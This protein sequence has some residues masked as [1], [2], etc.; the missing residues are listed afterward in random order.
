MSCPTGSVCEGGECVVQPR[1][2]PSHA[3]WSSGR[4]AFVDRTEA[5]G[6]VG[7]EGT[8]I[9]AVDY[10]GDGWTDL[11]V[12]RGVGRGDDDF[13]G[14]R[15]IW[16]LRNRGDGR[17]EDVTADSGIVSR[18]SGQPGGRPVDVVA[19]ADVDNDGDL[20]AYLG[21]STADLERTGGERSELMIQGPDHRFTVKEDSGD[22]RLENEI[23]SVAAASFVD[24]DL[25]GDVDLWTPHHGY[26]QGRR[27]VFRPPRLYENDGRGH[28]RDLT[29]ALGLLTRPW[30]NI[31]D[32][33]RGLA[34]PRAWSGAA[35]DLNN[36]GL[37]EL[38]AASYGRAPN[39]L[40]RSIGS[41]LAPRYENVSVASG[42]AYDDNMVWQDDQFARCYCQA[43]RSA[44]GCADVPPPMIACADHWDHA[45]GRQP[46]RL[47]GNSGATMC[48]DI[49]GDGDLDL[50]TTEIAHWWA[51]QGSDL[52]EVLINT[53]D[54]EVRFI[55]PGRASM[56]IEIPRDDPRGWNEGIMT[57]AIFDFD[58]DG[59]Q[60][61]YFGMSDYP[62]NHGVLFHQEERL[63]FVKVPREE[64]IDHNRSHGIAIADFD[65]DGDLDV[66]VGHS[67]M[68]CGPP[69]DCYPT[70]QVHFFENQMGGNFISLRLE[71]VRANRSA[72][73][74]RI[75]VRAGELLQVREVEG[76]YGL[77]GQQND[78]VQHFGLGPH[79]EAEVEI[80]WPDASLS[81]ERFRLA[82]GHRYRIVQ[83]MPPR[84]DDPPSAR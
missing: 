60:D 48:G 42:Y 81:R 74:A 77:Y 26:V 70:M 52:A 29:E 49:D 19:F 61:L 72:I 38:L 67:H 54:P 20:D 18:R 66:V 27:F 32:I 13:G 79:C 24:V 28:F 47:G 23:D 40:F 63:R 30:V 5:W 6:L 25:D 14:H 59:R 76:G 83:G 73:G 78:L 68:R 11:F 8:R 43:N 51:G 84:L 34:H 2:D 16:L 10:D 1:C 62:G 7:V 37:P 80:R 3:P 4:V 22:L 58:N 50:L 65:R 75:T 69:D 57:G 12:R 17:F 9:A 15:S 35:C 71:G 39:L 56:G 46:F 53:G 55:R 36:D 44:E 41:P 45:T 64:G 82:A 33:N 21:V 31:E